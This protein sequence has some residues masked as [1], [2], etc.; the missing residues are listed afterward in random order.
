MIIIEVS[1]FELFILG[2]II[3]GLIA[4]PRTFAHFNRDFPSLR[5]EEDWKHHRNISIVM[6]LFGYAG[7]LIALVSGKYGFKWPSKKEYDV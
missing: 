4:V 1:A 5:D 3:S 2:W 6:G 7:L